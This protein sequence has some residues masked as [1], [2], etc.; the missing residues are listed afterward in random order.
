MS[1]TR[2]QIEKADDLTREKV[3]VPE[4]EGGHVYVRVLE[5][6]H[7]DELEEITQGADGKPGDTKNFRA[8][9]ASRTLCDD[10][11]TLLFD[12][13]D[14][15]IAVLS[16]KSSLALD[17]VFEKALTL[18]KMGPGDVEELAKNSKRARKGASGSS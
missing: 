5:S 6:G 12:E 2:E 11:G 15:G 14:T 13:V 3:S 17:R 9:L 8:R 16:R 1:L 7:R 4:W 10:K 18:N